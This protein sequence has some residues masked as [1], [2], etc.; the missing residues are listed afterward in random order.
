[1]YFINQLNINIKNYELVYLWF[2]RLGTDIQD[3][4]LISTEVKGLKYCLQES[5]RYCEENESIRNWIA[6]V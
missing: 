4:R 1:M 3:D 6:S 5:L 2:S